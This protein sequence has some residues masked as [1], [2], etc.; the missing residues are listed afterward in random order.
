MPFTVEQFLDVF[1]SYNIAVFPI[2]IVFNLLALF[3]MVLV[4]KKYSFSSK[5]ISGILSFLWIWIGIVYHFIFFSS[6]N[7]AAYFFS[8]LFIAQSFIFFYA[9]VYKDYLKYELSKDWVGFIGG[10][11]IFYA[12]LLYPLLGYYFGHG[13]PYQPTFGLPCPTTI[14]TLGLLLFTVKKLKWYLIL[15]PVTWSLI[16]ATAAIKL[17]ILEDLGLFISGVTTFSILLLKK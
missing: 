7:D 15:I 11:F 4:I 9:G 5:V 13:Y 3:C 1:K 8:V 12:L 17:G 14:F 16:G 10:L 2:Q 6:I